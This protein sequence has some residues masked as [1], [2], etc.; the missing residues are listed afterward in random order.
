MKRILLF[1]LIFI[2]ITI[3]SCQNK[4]N[5]IPN[6]TNE[7]EIVNLLLGEFDNF[8]Q[9]WQEN[10]NEGIHIVKTAE[11]HRHIH[12][13]FERVFPSDVDSNEYFLLVTHTAGKDTNQIL[14][15]EVYEFWWMGEDGSN[16]TQIFSTIYKTSE[17]QGVITTKQ[18]LGE[19]S[20]VLNWEKKGTT[21]FA[22]NKKDQLVIS[23]KKDTLHFAHLPGIFKN[24]SE[25]EYQ[26]LRCRFFSGWI[27]Y[28]LPQIPDSTFFM[29]PL[30]IHDQGGIAQLQL[31][32]GTPIDYTVELTQLVY[33]KK[34]SLMKLAIYEMPKEDVSWNSRSAS[35]TWT[36]PDASRIGINLRRVVS[37][38]TL[39]EE[40][41]LNSN[42]TKFKK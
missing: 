37:G 17:N 15:R 40:G 10:T 12:S 9:C 19:N 30:K 1:I 16:E 41:Y 26:M 38:W 36:S 31:S 21:F 20:D 33:G 22:K 13:K 35:Y 4:S 11:K 7:E 18:A 28:P 34:I 25:G 42:N 3:I 32:D 14:S 23:L 2:T 24:Q 5:V 27:Q 6:S 29:R 8:Q 39:I